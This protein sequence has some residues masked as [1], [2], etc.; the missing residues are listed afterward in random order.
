MI[1]FSEFLS[2]IE[3]TNNRLHNNAIVV[4]NYTAEDLQYYSHCDDI[5]TYQFIVYKEND[6]CSNINLLKVLNF[7][8]SENYGFDIH[9]LNGKS[10]FKVF[11]YK[12]FKDEYVLKIKNKRALR[13]FQMLLHYA[14]SIYNNTQK[15]GEL[16]Q[17]I[18]L[19]TPE[20]EDDKKDFIDEF[21]FIFDDKE[22][23]VEEVL[24]NE[25]SYR[26]KSE[27]LIIQE[28]Q[29]IDVNKKPILQLTYKYLTYRKHQLFLNGRLIC[30]C[31]TGSGNDNLLK[32]LIDNPNKTWTRAELQ[33]V[34]ALTTN[35]AQNSSNYTKSFY[36]FLMDIKVSGKNG[37]SNIGKLFFGTDISKNSIHLK[38]PIYE[39]DLIEFN[40]DFKNDLELLEVMLKKPINNKS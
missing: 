18:N 10:P 37:Y 11:E 32:F 7:F 22:F 6:F 36:T 21:S 20:Y 23:V 35:T 15:Q 28:M 24:N 30:N 33:K 3:Y 1:K 19:P 4:D 13:T 31:N 9:N 39:E 29:K 16:M 12:D 25:A 40:I 26:I 14:K 34:N 8:N 5:K 2:V 17:A 27:N 38:N